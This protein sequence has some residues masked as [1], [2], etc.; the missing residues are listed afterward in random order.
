LFSIIFLISCNKDDVEQPAPPVQAAKKVYVCGAK[1]VSGGVVPALWI[2]NIPNYYETNGK[3][4][5]ADDLAFLGNDIYTVGSIHN[6]SGTFEIKYVI[7]K[8]YKVIADIPNI[9]GMPCSIAI[10]ENNSDLYVVGTEQL[11]NNLS[12]AKIWK[13][14]VSTELPGVETRPYDIEINNNNVYV[15]GADFGQN[16]HRAVLWK[17]GIRTNLTDGKYGATALSVAIVNND[18][19][20]AGSEKNSNGID[21]AKYWKNGVATNLTNG[22]FNAQASSI[23]VHN[24]N[25]YVG[26][27]EQT[28]NEFQQPKFWK[29]ALETTLILNA[30]Q[31]YV[32]AIAASN[33][34]V[35]SITMDF[36]EGEFG[37]ILWQD[38]K[39]IFETKGIFK[40]IYVR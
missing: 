30:Q 5:I 12:K 15:V 35:Y 16:I 4:G 32:N 25:I 19:Y 23:A 1:T 13:N 20:V 27:Y 37:F 28:A 26:G 33:N 8:N 9:G 6:T 36:Y 34:M 11:N 10:N 7:W 40:K 22:L 21:V 39:N 29:N 3:F 14:G 17:N 38:S 31:G 24:N 2:N 18:V